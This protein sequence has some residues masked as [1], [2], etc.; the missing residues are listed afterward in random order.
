MKITETERLILRTLE[1][2]DLDALMDIWGNEDVMK[3]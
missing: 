3:C 1:L 2:S